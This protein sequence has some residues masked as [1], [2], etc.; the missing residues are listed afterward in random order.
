MDGLFLMF[1]TIPGSTCTS[2]W[3][4]SVANCDV[5]HDIVSEHLDLHNSCMSRRSITQGNQD[6]EDVQPQ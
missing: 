6:S 4:V 2:L 1:H 5:G 3:F